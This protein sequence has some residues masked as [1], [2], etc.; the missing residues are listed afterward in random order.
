MSTPT[1]ATIEEAQA[2]IINLREQ[3]AERTNERDA[4]TQT[5]TQLKNDLEQVRTLNQKY[6][7]KLSAQY[8][9]QADE[10]NSGEEEVPTCEAFAL[11]LDII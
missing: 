4:L 7:N 5:N 9:P 3:L 8:T 6:F 1:Y 2:E 11:G 10:K